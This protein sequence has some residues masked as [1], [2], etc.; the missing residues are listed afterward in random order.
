[1]NSLAKVGLA[2]ACSFVAMVAGGAVFIRSGVYNIA[3]DDHHTRMTLAMI[4]KLRDHSIDLRARRIDAHDETG[5]ERMADGAQ[6]Y[7]A[8]CVDCHL[9]PGMTNSD[10]RKGLYPHP[11]NLAQEN[12][13]DSRRA[14]WTIKHGIKMSAMPAWGCTL[15][16]QAIWDIISFVRRMPAMSPETYQQL[17]VSAPTDPSHPASVVGRID[18]TV[19][20]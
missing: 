9:A 14:Y 19:Q 2:V 1:M 15:N 4:E 8:L 16:D 10:L 13:L 18:R 3:A 17:S 12:I 6:R 11:P 5:P 7:A 20:R